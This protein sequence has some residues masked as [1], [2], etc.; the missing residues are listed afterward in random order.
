V[1]EIRT[2]E[3]MV[4]CNLYN[5]YGKI[6][7]YLTYYPHRIK[8][9]MLKYYKIIWNSEIKIGKSFLFYI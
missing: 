9:S 8:I 6:D 2:T 1:K 4:L 3:F 5:L 7:F